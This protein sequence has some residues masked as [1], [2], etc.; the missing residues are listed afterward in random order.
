M[1]S[2]NDS[3]GFEMA[4]LSLRPDLVE[5]IR[6]LAA[7]EHQPVD[8]F[9]ESLL[10]KYPAIDNL[11]TAAEEEALFRAD[12]HRTY[13]DARRYWRSVGD[14]RSQLT[15]EQL[16][17]QFWQFDEDGVPHLKSEQA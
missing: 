17:E 15:D 7:R 13:E 8:E 3:E 11:R 9:V 14:E 12:R 5:R 1:S 16:A 6:D 2:E 10:S 4:E